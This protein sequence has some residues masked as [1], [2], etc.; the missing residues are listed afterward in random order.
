MQ[1][2]DL[3][4]GNSKAILSLYTDVCLFIVIARTTSS[5]TFC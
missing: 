1:R 4:Q 2:S 3:G 5:N